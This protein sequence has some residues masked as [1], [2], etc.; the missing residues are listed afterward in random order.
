MTSRA[1]IDPEIHKNYE[2]QYEMINSARAINDFQH[3]TTIKEKEN[4]LQKEYKFKSM[5]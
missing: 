2:N 4:Q 3:V 5:I 1:T